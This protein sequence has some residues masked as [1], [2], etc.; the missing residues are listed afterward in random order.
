[1]IMTDK[2]T[3]SIIGAGN[4]AGGF[5]EKKSSDSSGIFSHA[6]AYT[7]SGKFILKNIF[8][9]DKQRVEEFKEY[10]E[11]E[12]I[13]SDESDIINTYQDIIS[14]CSPDRFH[15]QT[16]KNIILNKS[17]KTIFVEKPLGLNLSQIKEVYELSLNS[18]INIVINFQRHF[19]SSYDMVK[20]M[21]TDILTV[22]AYYIKGLNH[23]GITMVDTLTMLFGYPDSVYSYNKVFNN[24]IKDFTYEFIIFYKDFNITIKTIDK[25]DYSYHIFDIDILLN[26]RRI[27][28]TDNGNSMIEY[29]LSDYAYSGVNVLSNNP[30]IH[31]T[32]YEMSML[33]SVEYLYDITTTKR[34]HNIN[35]VLDSYN[36]HILLDKIQESFKKEKKLLLEDKLWKK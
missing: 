32:Q 31:K 21:K 3:V 30:N 27:V 9:V 7:K 15:F 12:N 10:W 14:I 28:F 22:N 34:T 25:I 4:I 18:D 20:Q 26:N 17:C 23:I 33:N 35:T 5:D 16:L 19:D 29:N 1:M 36:N 6:G 8:D 11:V 24:E 13:V 2:L